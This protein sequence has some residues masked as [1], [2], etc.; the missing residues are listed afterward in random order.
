MSLRPMDT[1]FKTHMSP[2][3]SLLILG[4]LTP[5]EDSVELADEN[6]ERVRFDDTPDLVAI[7]VKVDTAIRSWE[8]ASIYRKR[9]I[10][11][12]LGGIHVTSCPEQNMPH[13]DAI[14]IGEAE[15][16]WPVLVEDV[17]AKRLKKVYRNAKNFDISRTPVPRWEL[18]AGKN[19]LYT[20]TLCL[21]RGC[22][23]QC[24]FCYSSTDG[25]TRGC[26]VK[27]IENVLAEIE[28][29][30]TR[31][32]MFID[33][34][35]IGNPSKAREVIQR[36]GPLGLTWHAAVSSDIG[37]QEDMLDLMAEN[38]CKSL[39]IGFESI[40]SA[41]L[42]LC[43]KR[44]NS[45]AE[46]DRTIR[47]IHKRGMMVNASLAFGFDTDGPDV[48]DNTLSWLI[49]NRIETMTAHILTPYPGTRFYRRLLDEG[50][51]I[52][53]DLRHY[54]TAHVVFSP[55]LMTGNE[56]QA[57]Y[58]RLYR[59]FYSWKGIFQRMPLDPRRIGAYL[60]F[61]L[62]YR[63]FGGF[64]SAFGKLGLMGVI[65]GIG[66]ALSYPDFFRAWRIGSLSQKKWS[67]KM[68]GESA[69]DIGH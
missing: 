40:N 49:R 25:F 46:Y 1:A 64:V 68:K 3:L 9:S 23:W 29:L 6:V 51:I 38:G 4:S 55:K 34:N 57:G 58:E 18:V 56:L 50:R 39:F 52:D 19:Y 44:Q 20:N 35:F 62:V 65:G 5:A 59:D 22:P 24:D 47:M 12:V 2:P 32:V 15:D 10:P 28:S 7:T 16:L 69:L 54:N 13:A 30:G 26:H 41:A 53:F 11:V 21:S 31:H 63:K 60:M 8:I 27:P 66:K 43:G 36:L 48:F 61:N 45:V 14:V 33:D 17:R 37:R 42:E 67:R